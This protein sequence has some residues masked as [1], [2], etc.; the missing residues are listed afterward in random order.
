MTPTQRNLIANLAS[1][2]LMLA[3][4]VACMPAILARVGAEAYGLVGLLWTLQS[5]AGVLDFGWGMAANREL[6]RLSAS[7]D[8]AG[9]MRALVARLSRSYLL[10]AAGVGA[11]AWFVAPWFGEAW[12]R[13]RELSAAEVGYALR[14]MG[15]VVALQ[16]PIAFFSSCVLGL[17]R[18]VPLSVVRCAS[19]AIGFPGAVALLSLGP[20]TIDR[21]L[22]AQVVAASCQL[23]GTFVILRFALPPAARAAGATDAAEIDWPAMRGFATGVFGISLAGLLLSYSDKLLLSKILSLEQ[24]GYYSLAA[25]VSSGLL[26]MA[27][28][29]FAVV[30][31]RFSQ[32]L[33]AHQGD[34][35]ATLYHQAS[36]FLAVLIVPLG[37][38]LSVSPEAALLAWTGRGDVVAH[39]ADILRWLAIGSTLIGLVN[40][41][42]ALQLA[43]GWTRLPLASNALAVVVVLPL[44]AILGTR[45]GPAAAATAWTGLGVAYVLVLTPLTLR[46]LLPNALRAW[47]RDDMLPTCL[48]SLCA[49][50]LVRCSLPA[51]TRSQAVLFLLVSLSTSSI[52][53]L[54]GAPASRH[55]LGRFFIRPKPIGEPNG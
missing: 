32:L 26:S 22:A 54:L 41:P 17:Q 40:V 47:I 50:L 45:H 30:L 28:P 8:N 37:L 29:V 33:A 3:L 43:H 44:M 20:P 23:V 52:A 2:G 31:P 15:V 34:A 19:L 18:A 13:P 7:P 38:L 16:I 35:I 42:Y 6:A 51:S 49:H 1:Q 27:Q 55:W 9:A 21:F 14:W 46:T 25:M 12:L 39:S 11:A 24:F 48:L 10:C 53:A 5:V 36:Q 4:G